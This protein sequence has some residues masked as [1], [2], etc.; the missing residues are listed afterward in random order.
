[1][2]HCVLHI[3]SYYPEDELFEDDQY[4]S[5]NK[6][7]SSGTNLSVIIYFDKLR[8]QY[9]LLTDNI[10][11]INNEETNTYTTIHK[12]NSFRLKTISLILLLLS[13]LS[14]NYDFLENCSIYGKYNLYK[15][16]IDSLC[17]MPYNT[18]LEKLTESNRVC[19]LDMFT[20]NKKNIDNELEMI[21]EMTI[22]N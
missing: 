2:S 17:N 21:K 13:R 11:F 12:Y 10:E 15:V 8:D 14:F 1:M 19:S 22:L 4:Y 18:F 16:N 9:V 7:V 3:I 6:Q 20:L 5:E